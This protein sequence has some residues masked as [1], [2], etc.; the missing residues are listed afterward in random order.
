MNIMSSYNEEVVVLEDFHFNLECIADKDA[1]IFKNIL[2]MHNFESCVEKPI[3]EQDDWLD[4]VATKVGLKALCFDVS[5]LDHKVLMWKSQLKVTASMYKT[6]KVKK[7]KNLGVERFISKLLNT[8][9]VSLNDLCLDSA[10]S[11]YF[12]TFKGIL[13]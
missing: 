2:H 10:V 8:P 6:F 11:K 7:W 5:F 1:Q 4:V 9:L 13:D 3:Y 12:S